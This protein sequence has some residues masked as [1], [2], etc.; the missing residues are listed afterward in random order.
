M[1]S[2]TLMFSIAIGL[3]AATLAHA[4]TFKYT[5][6]FDDGSKV[7]GT[8]DGVANGNLVSNLSN[9]SV[10]IDGVAFVGNGSL[11]DFSWNPDRT[12]VR[13][14]ATASFNGLDNNFFFVDTDIINDPFYTNYFGIAHHRNLPFFEDNAQD[15]NGNIHMSAQYH[16]TKWTLT[17]L[18]PVPEP[19]SWAMLLAGMGLIGG[20]AHRRRQIASA[21]TR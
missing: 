20:M 4:D 16:P 1:K 2:N 8:F 10:A 12:L 6:Q 21:N 13:G 14:G 19:E 5:W 15:L 11:L 9:I 18:S 7:I 3:F 17:K